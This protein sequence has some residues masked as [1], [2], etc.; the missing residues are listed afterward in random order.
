MGILDWLFG[1]G[2]HSGH[3][4]ELK[5]VVPAAG[6]QPVRSFLSAV[7]GEGQPT[8]YGADRQEIIRNKVRPGNTVL[9]AREPD[10]P[11]DPNAIGLW[12]YDE[13]SRTGDHIGYIPRDRAKRMASELDGGKTITAKVHEVTGGSGGKRHVGVVLE[14][15]V[16]E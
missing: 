16:W 9:L 5:A 3:H 13:R 10:N 11:H 4:V 8:P 2:S 12:W 15:T 6:E 7:A 14:L 1:G